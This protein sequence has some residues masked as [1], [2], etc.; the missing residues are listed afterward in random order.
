MAEKINT[1]PIWDEITEEPK[2]LLADHLDGFDPTTMAE[3]EMR[4]DLLRK[5]LK[6]TE[7]TEE[8]ADEDLAYEDRTTITL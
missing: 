1:E 3:P 5:R 4:C 8:L 7:R 2:K 6:I